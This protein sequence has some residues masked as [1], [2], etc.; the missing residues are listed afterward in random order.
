[1]TKLLPA[2]V[3]AVLLSSAS[4]AFADPAPVNGDPGYQRLASWETR[5]D[6]R[7]ASGVRSGSLDPRQAWKLQ[8]D[9]DNVEIQ[10]LQA[11]YENNGIDPGA[12]HGFADR[13]RRISYQVGMTDS[14]FGQYGYGPPP[15]PGPGYGPPPGPGYGP[16]PG[17]PP[18]YYQQGQYESDC[19]RG[20]AAAGT[21]FG[22]IAGGL[23]GGAASHGNGGAIAGGVILGGLFGNAIASDV[24]CDDR[25]DAFNTYSV[26]LN[27]DIGRRYDWHHN[28][29]NGY[30]TV[31][32]EYRDGGYVCRDFHTVTFRDGQRFDRDGSACRQADGNWRFR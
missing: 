7:I 6:D 10:S 22:A 9:L 11:H 17:P 8:K 29:H 30:I 27:G 12:F 20:N 28:D 32:R 15:G 1:M 19:H 3:A 2:A 4:F 21:V 25:H 5:L 13:L 18:G 24:Q 26:A 23:I 16:P 31:K 14:D